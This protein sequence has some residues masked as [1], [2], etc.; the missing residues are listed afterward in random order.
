[1][2]R[3]PN[4]EETLPLFGLFRD[5]HNLDY[6]Q[7]LYHQKGQNTFP[8]VLN[9]D[10]VTVL[11][12]QNEFAYRKG[13][14][15]C[16]LRESNCDLRLLGNGDKARW[17]FIEIEYK[18]NILDDEE[19]FYRTFRNLELTGFSVTCFPES[20]H[21][22]ETMFYPYPDSYFSLLRWENEP[23]YNAIKIKKT[24]SSSPILTRDSLII[25]YTPHRLSHVFAL[26]GTDNEGFL[27]LS[28]VF[29]KKKQ[30]HIAID[31][32]EGFVFGVSYSISQFDSHLFCQVEIEYWSRIVSQEPNE[33]STHN[34]NDLRLDSH[35]RLIMSMQ[36][37]LQRNDVRFNND[38]I[39]KNIWLNNIATSKTR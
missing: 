38:Q 27:R 2:I 10:I 20:F 39:P 14:F 30:R 33:Y 7:T 25:D 11:K 6:L 19:E 37:F 13:F 31:N 32:K 36:E 4:N 26:F 23:H 17:R 5:S 8:I 12:I 28:S 21:S 35:H 1:M 3:L 9:N 22:V 24:L 18:I 15:P 16:G 34:D 29:V